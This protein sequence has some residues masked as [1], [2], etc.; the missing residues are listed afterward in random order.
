MTAAGSTLVLA[1]VVGVYVLLIVAN[2]WAR[3]HRRAAAH[4]WQTDHAH[5]MRELEQYEADE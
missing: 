3:H 1:V 5:L 4:R 2:W